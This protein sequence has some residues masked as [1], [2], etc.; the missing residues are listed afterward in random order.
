MLIKFLHKNLNL[1]FYDGRDKEE[2]K[3]FIPSFKVEFIGQLD[4]T[5]YGIVLGNIDDFKAM[6]D[7]Y[8]RVD[9]LPLNL[10]YF[11]DKQMGTPTNYNEY[12]KIRTRDVINKEIGD[13]FDLIADVSKRLTM[14]ERLI[15]LLA[16]EVINNS[17]IAPMVKERYQPLLEMYLKSPKKDLSDLEDPMKLFNKLLQRGTAITDIVIDNYVNL[18]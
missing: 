7:V 8:D 15:T 17:D 2:A 4:E 3:E 14:N 12:L 5:I 18:K 10:E 6:N 11:V 13:V 1:P 16:Y 9:T